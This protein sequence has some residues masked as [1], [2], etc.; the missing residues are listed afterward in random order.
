MPTETVCVDWVEDQLF[1]MR[2]RSGFPIV[3]A[4]PGGANA[5]DLLPLSLIGCAAWDVRAILHKQR[6]QVTALR[7]TAE[8]ERDEQPPW[9]F[10]KIRIRYTITGRN[11]SEGHVRR[12][13]EL[14]ET[15]YCS[16]YATLRDAVELLSEVEIIE[17]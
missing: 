10:R 3:M 14:T 7:V 9:R 4:Q 17:A 15:K 12:A 2:D 6:Q 13:I 1:L 16:V 11:L 5:A 8:S